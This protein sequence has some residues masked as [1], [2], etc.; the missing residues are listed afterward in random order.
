MGMDLLPKA[1][2]PAEIE[3]RWSEVWEKEKL[4][5]A[6][7]KKSDKQYSIVIPPPNVTGSLHMGHALNNTL[8]DILIRYKRM[9]G[10]NTLWMPGMDHAGIA[11][12]NVVEKQLHKE[13]LSR[14]DL[15]REKFIERVWSWKEHSGGV[16]L[17]QLKRLGCSCDWDR[18]RFTMD[19]GLSRAVREV[20]VRLYEE[21]LIYK[22]D[23]IV[24]WCPRCH[25][26]LS[27]LEVDHEDAS[28]YLWHI[29]YPVEDS[30]EAL[31]IATTRP[32]TMLGDTAVAVNPKDERYTHL[33][34]RYAILPLVG[35]RMKIIADSVVGMDFGTGALKVTPSHDLTDFEL[36]LRHDL[37]RVTI[38]DSNGRINENG[39]HYSGMDRYECREAIVEELNQKG[40]LVKMEPYTVGLG[41]CYRCKDVVEPLISK[42]WFVKVETLARDALDA[43][44]NGATTI[45]PDHWTK[46]YYEWMT[47]IRDWCISRQIW[48]GHRIPA[49]ACEDCDEIIVK[50]ETPTECPSCKGSRLN[51]E[52]DVL[53]T[54]FSSALWPFSTMGWPEETPLLRA[55]YPTSCLV[56]GFDILFFWVARMMMMGLKF[57]DD[58]PFTD[59]YIHALVRDENGKK[60][61]KSLGNVIDPLMVMDRYG[62]D[63][64]RFTLAALA[65]QGRDIRMSEKRIEGY[66]H[67]INKIWNTA[68]FALPYLEGLEGDLSSK[69]LESLSLSERWIISR[70]NGTI[71]EV[72]ESI[73]AYRF[74]DAAQALYQFTWHEFCDWY[75]E[76]AKLPLGGDDA[77]SARRAAHVLKHVLDSLMRLLHPFIPFITEEIADKIPGNGDTIVSGPFPAF[78]QFR[79][80]TKSEKEMGLIMELITSVRTIR[81]EMN[82]PPSSKLPVVIHPSSRD[83]QALIELNRK[84][85]TVLGRVSE[86]ELLDP[87]QPVKAPAMSATAVVGNSR[88]FVPLEG[89]VDPDAEMARLDKEIAKV[90]KELNAVEKKLS[91]ENFLSKAKPEAVQKQKER[92]EDL[93]SKISGLREAWEK[94]T[95][96]KEARA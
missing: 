18:E 52:T 50:R 79:L 36:S 61:S 41:R 16:I 27:D 78:D 86:M 15:G 48:W 4:F 35:R 5:H 22:G 90:E 72:H 91:N 56:T 87:N 26:A 45:V 30:D 59:V 67:F 21:G 19:E 43:V 24:N 47:N 11:T 64:F 76:T 12:Q 93:S 46:T 34:G 28:G 29:R 81:A 42:Q 68:R 82:L 37:D 32:E 10:Y 38:M 8:Q 33:Q 74:N 96:L 73:G 17:N 23:Y 44:K 25:T 14:Q 88:V 69:D 7:E 65:A 51:Q 63:A 54:W 62:T 94:M 40:F 75:I 3:Q 60:M 57:L 1:Y 53:D 58:V 77:D 49:W 80:D 6:D 71:R 83:E 20:F 31:V 13:G 55:F 92:K 66:R 39:I 70:L 89:I 2:D 9:N 84:M 95:K 85:I